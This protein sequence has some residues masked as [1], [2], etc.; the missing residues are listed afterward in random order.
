VYLRQHWRLYSTASPSSRTIADEQPATTANKKLH[1]HKRMQRKL[2]WRFS[3][4]QNT[5]LRLRRQRNRNWQPQHG[6]AQLPVPIQTSKPALN[7][8]AS[9]QEKK[10]QNYSINLFFSKREFPSK[11]LEG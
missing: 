9:L 6:T 3:S 1:M 8:T 4:K 10:K 11:T 7:Q 2:H 5:P